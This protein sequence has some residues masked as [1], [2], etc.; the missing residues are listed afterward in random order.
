LPWKLKL[1]KIKFSVSSI[2]ARSSS[3][4][5]HAALVYA[6]SLFKKKIKQEFPQQQN[7]ENRVDSAV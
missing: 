6:L 3:Q 1:C 5:G 2:S 7:K 4:A